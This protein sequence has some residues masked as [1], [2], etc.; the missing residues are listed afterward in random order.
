MAA[1]KGPSA[2][3][4][5]GYCCLLRLVLYLACLA[6]VAVPTLAVLCW[7][8]WLYLGWYRLA[9]RGAPGSRLARSQQWQKAS[10]QEWR[11]K[12]AKA[13]YP[14]TGPRIYRVCKTFQVGPSRHVTWLLVSLPG[15]AGKRAQRQARLSSYSL[16]RGKDTLGAVRVKYAA[17]SL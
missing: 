5:A 11:L 15:S 16:D 12:F 13:P 9:L 14:A 17:A 3:W 2:D 6:L 1:R 8:G 10:P 7:L 4:L